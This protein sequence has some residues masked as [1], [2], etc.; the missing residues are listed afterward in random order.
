MKHRISFCTVCMNRTMHLKQTLKRNISDNEGYPDLEFVVLDYGS[1]DDLHDWIHTELQHEINTGRVVYF[2]TKDPQFFHM[3]HSK[4]MAFRLATG[5]ILCGIDADNYTGPGFA[6]YVNDMFN[7]D[8]DIYLLP[9]RIGANKKWWDVQGRICVKQTDFYALRGYDEKVKD[10]GYEDKD[11]KCRLEAYGR[12][13][14]TIKDP[15]F[16]QA[17]T[18][19]DTMRMADGFSTKKTKEVLVSATTDELT[20]II[21]LEENN[22]F[23][24]F[25][26][27]GETLVSGKLTDCVLHPKKRF[28]GIYKQDS[29]ELHLYKENGSLFQTLTYKNNNHLLGN[30]GETFNR[31]SS[32]L[33]RENFLLKRAIYVGKKIF[34]NNKIKGGVMNEDGFGQGT[35]YRNFSD[36]AIHLGDAITADRI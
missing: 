7:Q 12:K 9:P 11:F 36:I 27:P 4:N 16:L 21:Y 15:A 26:V 8:P 33:L 30:D 14:V 24:I 22:A 6:A 13:G 2:A 32:D 3:S 31:I 1:K 28:T 18:H 25:Y 17:I 23:E 35:V 34:Y 29:Q 20:A 5:D 10:Y 19:T